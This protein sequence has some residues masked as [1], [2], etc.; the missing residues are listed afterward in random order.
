MPVMERKGKRKAGSPVLVL[1]AVAAAAALLLTRKPP[2]DGTGPASVSGTVGTI[3]VTQGATMGTHRLAKLFFSTLIISFE[4]HPFTHDAA[5]NLISW[6]YKIDYQLIEV[7]T[8]I[9][10]QE[11]ELEQ[12]T[13]ISGP[14]FFEAGA[15]LGL[16]PPGVYN[17]RAILKAA[18][19]DA[20]GL[21]QAGNWQTV[22]N[23]VHTNAIL[24]GG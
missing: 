6:P 12:I 5:G 24:A 11:A 10:R 17:V 18:R 7:A 8:G 15:G 19:S 21:P 4:W 3:A 16:V 14:L 1:V 9:V 22:H 23:V 13:A 20:N 2:P